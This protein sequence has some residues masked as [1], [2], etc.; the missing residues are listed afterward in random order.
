[1][2]SKILFFE[3]WQQLCKSTQSLSHD[4]FDNAYNTFLNEFLK[5][6]MC[7]VDKI[8]EDYQRGKN[9][10][11]VENLKHIDEI[12]G[13]AFSLYAF[14]IHSVLSFRKSL[15]Q[16]LTEYYK[17]DDNAEGLKVFT[18]LTYINGRALQ[19]AN[20]ILLLLRNGYADGAYARF[21]TLY[22][23][24]VIAHFINS[25][26]DE[27]AQAYMDYDGN[28]YGWAAAAFP[29]YK[30]PEKIPF[31]E[32][33]KNCGVD[34]SSWK[35]EYRLSNKLV[36]ASS[37]GTFSRLSAIY[38]T[39]EILIG[40]SDGGIKVPATNSLQALF[41]INRLYFSC[42]NA[43]IVS[44]WVLTLQEL[45]E[46][47]CLKFENINKIHFPKQEEQNNV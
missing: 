34:V 26:G 32:I 8:I 24:S 35:S 27:F 5:G 42:I 19:V 12:W 43:P 36:H 39:K 25:H 18:V 6:K 31:N 44:L 2:D 3:E 21:R 41:Q 17:I 9:Q 20:E 4:E 1:M 38:P 30:K 22:E 33:E 37:Q 10:E 29:N 13:P 23:L 28:R 46:K 16:Y 7:H 11:D 14:Y 45:K 47:C 15:M 40:A